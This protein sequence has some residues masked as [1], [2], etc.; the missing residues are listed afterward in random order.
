[1]PA[2]IPVH[3]GINEFDSINK[4]RIRYRDI[5]HSYKPTEKLSE[6]DR[7]IIVE[8]MTESKYKDRNL[9]PVEEVVVKRGNYGR[10]CFE[11]IKIDSSCETI[12]IIGS[13]RG[14]AEL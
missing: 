13:V 6:N 9:L 14:C 2:K 1:M 11:A 12:S 7:Q 10:S 3:I 5:L 4:A 8:L